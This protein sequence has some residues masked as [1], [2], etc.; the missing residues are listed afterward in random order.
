MKMKL[1]RTFF[2]IAA[3]GIALLTTN[4]SKDVLNRQQEFSIVEEDPSALINNFVQQMELYNKGVMLKGGQRMLVDSAVWYIDATLNY[5]Y[6]NAGHSF[7]KLH[8]DTLYT[9]MSLVNGYEAAYEEVFDA[10][11]TFLT[12]LSHHFYEEIEG[13]NKQFMMARVDDMGSLPGNKQKLRIITVTGT[14]TL[15]QTEDFG[16]EETFRYEDFVLEDCFGNNVGTNAPRLFEAL[17]SQHFNPEPSNTNCRW[18]FFGSTEELFLDYN[19]HPLD[20]TPDNYLDYKI[21]A[22]N[23]SVA[24]F[25]D[26]TECLEYDYNGSGIH[27]MQFYYDH[28]KGLINAWLSSS[29]NTGN[30][31][32]AES[33]ILSQIAYYD[34]KSYIWHEPTIHFRKRG[35]VCYGII[36]PLPER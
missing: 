13:D 36:D 19:D 23:E 11:E 17:L 30:K 35:A 9:E 4:C 28:L 15:E 3:V 21:F 16:N 8:R 31:K 24:N 6:A 29:Q 34:S 33:S 5:T 20:P 2:V 18:Y 25:D 27:E 22:A 14:G 32:F 26:S 1:K 12:G 10:Y 7:E